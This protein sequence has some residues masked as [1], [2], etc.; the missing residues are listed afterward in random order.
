MCASGDGDIHLKIEKDRCRFTA[1]GKSKSLFIPGGWEG[2]V[3]LDPT[4]SPGH[5]DIVSENGTTFGI[6]KLEGDQLVVVLSMEEHSRPPDFG[7][8]TWGIERVF[9]RTK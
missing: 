2:T 5:F 3:K 6:Y 1:E 7:K 8:S 9:Q 4:K